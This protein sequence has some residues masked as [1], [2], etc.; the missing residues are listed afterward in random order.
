MA[1]VKLTGLYRNVSKKTGKAYLTG[2][3]NFGARVLVL[4]NP[5]KAKPDAAENTP[6]FCLWLVPI[7]PDE[8]K[9]PYQ[10]QQRPEPQPATDEL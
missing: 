7:V 1:G 5:D 8:N 6:D 2:K 10:P 9:P 4:P 3:L